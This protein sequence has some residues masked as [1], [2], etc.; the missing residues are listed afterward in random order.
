MANHSQG[1]IKVSPFIVSP[2][3]IVHGDNS[4]EQASDFLMQQSCTSYNLLNPLY[5]PVYDDVCQL[6][7]WHHD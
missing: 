1:F 5:C 2:G 4:I 7:P 3:K 6:C